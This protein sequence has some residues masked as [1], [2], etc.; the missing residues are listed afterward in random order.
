MERISERIV[1]MAEKRVRREKGHQKKMVGKP[2]AFNTWGIAG[3][4]EIMELRRL[5]QL[6]IPRR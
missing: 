6:R 3:R 5:W 1:S 2:P 4:L